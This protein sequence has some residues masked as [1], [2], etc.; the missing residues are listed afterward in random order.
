MT[1]L[2]MTRDEALAVA[3]STEDAYSFDRY[4]SWDACALAL[5]GL[6]YDVREATAILRSK[7]MRWA[8]DFSDKGYGRCT[9]SDLLRYLVKNTITDTALAELVAFT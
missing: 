4:K 3:K 9:S 7:H 5:R 6:G 2:K 1:V 8:G